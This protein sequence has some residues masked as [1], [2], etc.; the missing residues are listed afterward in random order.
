MSL[1]Q[2]LA[3]KSFAKPSADGLSTFSVGIESFINQS[4]VMKTD[5][6][7]KAIASLESAV[8]DPTQHTET[9]DAVQTAT[10]AVKSSVK[11]EFYAEQGHEIDPETGELAD[12]DISVDTAEA[13]EEGY[14][15]E[16]EN[17]QVSIEAAAIALLAT[18]DQQSYFDSVRAKANATGQ[19]IV[20]DSPINFSVE[21]F[22]AAKFHE[23]K[24][25]TIDFNY[26]AAKQSEVGRVF[27]PMVVCTPEQTLFK[28][29]ITLAALGKNTYHNK[30]ELHERDNL[31]TLQESYRDGSMFED[32]TL[33]LVPC[34]D[35]GD[36]DNEWLA[37]KDL[38]ASELVTVEGTEFNTRSL[39]PGKVVDLIGISQHPGRLK[40]GEANQNTQI[41]P[42]VKLAHLDILV[43]T[44]TEEEVIRVAVAKTPGSD[45][46]TH[47]GAGTDRRMTLQMINRGQIAVIPK[48][49]STIFK[50]LEDIG[51]RAYWDLDLNGYCEIDRGHTKVNGDIEISQI[52]DKDGN[53]ISPDLAIKSVE[54]VGYAVDARASN[55][56]LAIMADLVA[57]YKYYEHYRVGLR[58]PIAAHSALV[59]NGN[60]PSSMTVQ[61][62]LK[63]I[64]EFVRSQMDHDAHIQLE[65]YM[66]QMQVSHDYR[67]RSGNLVGKVF[68]CEAVRGVAAKI[69]TPIKLETEIDLKDFVDTRRSAER[70]EDVKGAFVAKLIAVVTKLDQSSGFSIACKSYGYGDE[71]FK[72]VAKILTSRRLASLMMVN[73]DTRTLGPEF[74][75]VVAKTDRT[76]YR[77]RIVVQLSA[78]QRRVG[79][80]DPLVSG[81]CLYI[82][83]FIGEFTLKRGAGTIQEVAVQPHYEHIV[84]VPVFAD[85]AV[86]HVDEFFGEKTVDKV[87]TVNP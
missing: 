2:K 75:H 11:Q 8:A 71:N 50:P 13:L 47:Q 73:G 5:G 37:D 30:K 20:V 1:L 41:S 42:N 7:K 40:E 45:F 67:L 52:L 77:D 36:E 55:T 14:K 23:Y 74:D 4:H 66:D 65:N 3:K 26:R 54:L 17:N 31:I 43:K 33:K 83:E 60:N 59:K 72:P 80:F 32:E 58:T 48:A 62:K 19:N 38:V 64:T 18:Q 63:V 61:E 57:C 82:P 15:S 79:E 39:R 56:D 53:E 49:G 51:A 16:L 21:S 27:F 68:E 29:E 76:I 22:D 81:H 84:N 44:E 87:E 78:P 9:V 35:A 12:T 85:I 25:A 24:T 34:V 70:L 10:D 46:A 6:A 28:A 69:L 86:K